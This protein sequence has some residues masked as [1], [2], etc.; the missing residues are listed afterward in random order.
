MTTQTEVANAFAASEDGPSVASNF[1]RI[2]SADGSKEYLCGGSNGEEVV[3]ASR[4]PMGRFVVFRH[5]P[6]HGISMRYS[7][8]RR[9][10]RKARRRIRSYL[11]DAYGEVPESLLDDRG[12]DTPRVDNVDDIE[13]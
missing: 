13:I 3:L 4:E 11:R 5:V 2:E 1:R 8:V 6:F 7:S 10:S 9:Q 12:E